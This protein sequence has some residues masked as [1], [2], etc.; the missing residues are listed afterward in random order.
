MALED[1]ASP[2]YAQQVTTTI[3]T[4]G[5]RIARLDVALLDTIDAQLTPDDRRSLLALHAA[6]RD[7]YGRFTYLEI[8][9]HLGGSLQSFVCDDACE[10]IVSLD[11]RPGSQP[12]ERGIVYRYD[13]NST[14]R[15]LSNLS[16]LPAADLDKLTTIDAGTDAITPACLPLRPMLCFVDGEHTDGAALR[17]ARFCRAAVA[18]EGCIAFHDAWIVYRGLTAFLD[19]LAADGVPFEAFVL[20]SCV[21]AV[22]LGTTSLRE[23]ATLARWQ[24]EG[25]R[26]YLHALLSTEPYRAE[27]MRPVNRALRR[28]R[29]LAH[30]R[31]G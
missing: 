2:S 14:P 11:P 22:E 10:A 30:V 29:R 28:V 23:S 24:R 7:V 18:D 21:L 16:A 8:G 17:D 1:H 12:D 27:Y 31:R 13:G 3:E 6:C 9:S 20:P 4:V 26:A 19:E 15:M 25:Y 5:D